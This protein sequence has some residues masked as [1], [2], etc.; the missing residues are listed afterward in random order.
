[1]RDL[2]ASGVVAGECGAAGLAGLKTLREVGVL[3]T[4]AKRAL[5]ISSE[6][7]TDPAAYEQIV[8]PNP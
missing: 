3:P 4:G 8:R 2:A 5:I 6:G 7:A 1:M